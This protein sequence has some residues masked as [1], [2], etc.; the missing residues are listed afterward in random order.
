MMKLPPLLALSAVV[1]ALLIPAALPADPP[2]RVAMG[3][4]DGVGKPPKVQWTP[5]RLTEGDISP[6]AAEGD[7]ATLQA[8]FSADQPIEEIDFR[9]SGSLRNFLDIADLALTSLPDEPAAGS[10]LFELNTLPDDAG[11]TIGGTVQMIADGKPIARPLVFSL[12]QTEDDD[13]VNDDPDPNNDPNQGEPLVEDDGSLPVSWEVDQLTSDLFV[14][15]MATLELT[16]NRDLTDVRLWSTPSLRGCLDVELLDDGLG[17]PTQ[18]GPGTEPIL[19]DNGVIAEWPAG[20]C[21]V[22]KFTLLE[23]AELDADCGGTV[24][25]RGA[26]IPPRTYPMVLAVGDEDDDDDGIEDVDENNVSPLAVVNAGSFQ[27]EPVA[28]GQI[29]SVF[30]QNLGPAQLEVFQLNQ[31]GQ[32]D[33]TLGD[34]MVL[35]DGYPGRVL[36][37]SSN[38]VNVIVPTAVGGDSAELLVL[39]G[40]GRST[41]YPIAVA[42]FAPSVFTLDGSGRGQAAA[43]NSNGTV[44]GNSNP[45]RFSTVVTLFA[46]GLGPVE[47]PYEAG[48]VADEARPL[49]AD[50]QVFIGGVEA[51]VLYAGSAPGLVAGVTQINVRVLATMPKG[52]QDVVI[53]VDGVESPPDVQVAIQ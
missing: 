32:V 29:A 45:A 10:V 15:G 16:A 22:V 38:Q 12:H 47:P 53:V 14:D 43:L 48:K 46:T 13:D 24:H 51:D 5:S 40:R 27:E 30:G 21:L 41:L 17:E 26:G 36:S 49:Q 9:L 8:E 33:E 20:E 7:P 52:P 6:G 34:V 35:F 31:Q 25:V 39:N 37:A 23:D 2:S 42:P 1:L 3:P 4:P 11:Q 28:P 18:C 50:I 19:F 44:N